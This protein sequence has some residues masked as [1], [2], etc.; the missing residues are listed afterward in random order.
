[1]HKFVQWENNVQSIFKPP[2]IKTTINTVHFLSNKISFYN[3][4]S[5]GT[6]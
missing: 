1:M 6:T 3:E 4:L 2:F 5:M